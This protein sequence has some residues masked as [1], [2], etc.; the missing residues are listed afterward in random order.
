M[1]LKSTSRKDT[2][3]R[4][5][6]DYLHK[7]GRG[8]DFAITYLHNIDTRPDDLEGIVEI[9]K[10]NDQFRKKRKNG[11]VF[12]HEIMAFAPEDRAAIIRQ[13]DL[14]RDLIAKYIELRSPHAIVLARPHLEEKHIHIHF[15][16]SANEAG[17]HTSQRISKKELE[18]IKQQIRAY[19]QKLFPELVHSYR[20]GR[21]EGTI[22]TMTQTTWQMEK[23]GAEQTQKNKLKKLLVTAIDQ[24]DSW[25]N[26]VDRLKKEGIEVYNRQSRIVGVV[27]QGR[28]YRFVTLMLEEQVNGVGRTIA[29][30]S[31]E[32]NAQ[33][34][35]FNN[36]P[37][38]W[39]QIQQ[40]LEGMERRREKKQQNNIIKGM[41][42]N[43]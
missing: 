10:K 29:N 1:I 14:L 34:D 25:E 22:K 2:N 39:Q 37:H 42:V 17:H 21:G 28:R 12:F 27:W 9:F 24:V 15:V 20:S 30:S 35:T 43:K 36:L 32:F 4:Q 16:I 13:P 31:L 23:R 7:E 19:Q 6:V 3:F 26:L 18:E 41:N 40:D 8:E 11:V 33:K 38:D 5:I